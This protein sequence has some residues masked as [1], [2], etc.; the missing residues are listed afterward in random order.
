MSE[1]RYVFVVEWFDAQ[2][3]VIKKFYFNYY[4]PGH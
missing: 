2:S 1:K 4:L 3:S